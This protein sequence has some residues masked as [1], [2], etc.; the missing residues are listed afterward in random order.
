MGRA[1]GAAGLG[2][3]GPTRGHVWPC[4]LF[5]RHRQGQQSPSSQCQLGPG[6][7]R[8]ESV[9]CPVIC[10]SPAASTWLGPSGARSLPSRPLSQSGFQAELLRGC[11]TQ[12]PACFF[13]TSWIFNCE[14]CGILTAQ[15]GIEPL[16][17]AEVVITGPPRK[18][19]LLKLIFLRY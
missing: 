18:S 8:T 19:L 7:L 10:T 12:C 4:C 9:Q 17:K 11:Q 13:P 16:L 6:S 3:G 14:V 2:A 5:G 15:P 1:Q